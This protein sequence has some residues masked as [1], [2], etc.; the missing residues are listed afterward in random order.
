MFDLFD[1]WDGRDGLVDAAK[2]G[3]LL[4]CT[5]LNP[6]NALIKRHGG[7]EKFGMCLTSRDARE[8]CAHVLL[9]MS[10]CACAVTGDA[11]RA[12]V[13]GAV[14][15]PGS[16]WARR[17]SRRCT[18]ELRHTGCVSLALRRCSCQRCC[19]VTRDLARVDVH[20][21]AGEDTVSGVNHA[22]CD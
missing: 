8:A 2:I 19:V 7:T 11:V 18:S 20:S 22:L 21:D 4:R 16:R 17:A 13:P 3:D 9:S 1:F 10:G 15:G 12:L 6:T 14:S 5:G